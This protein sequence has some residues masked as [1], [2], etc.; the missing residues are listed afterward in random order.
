MMYYGGVNAAWGIVCLVAVVA[1]VALIAWA[2]VAST[3]RGK[4]RQDRDGSSDA[5]TVLDRRFANGDIDENE[6]RQ[7]RQLLSQH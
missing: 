2:I 5:I 4:A 7:R 6:Y 3:N 1:I